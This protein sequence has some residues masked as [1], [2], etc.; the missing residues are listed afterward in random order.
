MCEPAL[1]YRRI[2]FEYFLSIVGALL[3]YHNNTLNA[4]VLI[5]IGLPQDKGEGIQS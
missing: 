2:D 1:K 3:E 5:R 4:G